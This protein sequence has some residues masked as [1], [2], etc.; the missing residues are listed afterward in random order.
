VPC[1]APEGPLCWFVGVGHPGAVLSSHEGPVADLWLAA[2]HEW[3]DPGALR[4]WL[5]GRP[6]ATTAKDRARLPDDL[7]AAAWV[8]CLRLEGPDLSWLPVVRGA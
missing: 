6:L 3:V 2:D 1:E 8:R 4:R 5:D 7:A